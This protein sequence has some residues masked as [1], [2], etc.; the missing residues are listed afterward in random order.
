[1]AHIRSDH[2]LFL[3]LT[4]DNEFSVGQISVKELTVD[5]HMIF[6]LGKGITH[7]LGHAEAVTLLVI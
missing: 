7:N 2:D 1:M 6:S 4:G 3:G 5:I